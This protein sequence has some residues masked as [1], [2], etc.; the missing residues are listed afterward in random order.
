MVP[1]AGR[2]VRA[3]YRHEVLAASQPKQL[4]LPGDA[5][6]HDAVAL[7]AGVAVVNQCLNGAAAAI[8]VDPAFDRYVVGLRR[9]R[10]CLC[11]IVS[12][13]AY[14]ASP[15]H[16]IHRCVVDR[17][18]VYPDQGAVARCQ[19]IGRHIVEAC[20]AIEVRVRREGHRAVG[21]QY[22]STTRTAGNR[23]NR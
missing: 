16:T 11:A 7:R 15:Q 9:D 1:L 5:A 10:R 20:R 8:P 21:V 22:R 2:D 14:V 19:T 23:R 6:A 17:G 4:Q 18:Y 12:A 3:G 13:E